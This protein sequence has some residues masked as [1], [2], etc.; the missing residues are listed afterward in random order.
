MKINSNEKI[1]LAQNNLQRISEWIS[2]ADQK[3]GITLVFQ[4]GLVAFITS[5]KADDIKVII[6]QKFDVL[7]FILYVA[8]I[9]FIF[10]IIKA[11]Y[12]AFRA[13]SPDF[14]VREDS[15]FFF[16]SIVTNGLTKFKKKF[17]ALTDTDAEDDLNN[18]VFI[19]SQI[20]TFKFAQ[21]QKAIFYTLFASLSWLVSLILVAYF[22]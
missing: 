10:F 15:L 19:N 17:S 21:V 16:G 4:A 7:H 14:N 2:H 13:L 18:Q 9:T 5:S 22:K 1:N 6:T 20:A 8:L 11:A 12:H 3:V